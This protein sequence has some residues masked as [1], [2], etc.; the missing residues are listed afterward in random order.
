ME[1]KG[2]HSPA[3]FTLFH[4]IHLNGYKC[5]LTNV[6]LIGTSKLISDLLFYFLLFF[7]CLCVYMCVQIQSLQVEHSE[8]E[9]RIGDYEEELTRA[10]EELLQLQEE[11]RQLGDKVQS[12][13]DQ[14]CPL[15]DAVKE[16]HTQIA[17]VSE[18]F[19]CF[20]I[21][22]ALTVPEVFF[23]LMNIHIIPCFFLKKSHVLQ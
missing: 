8:Q 1:E 9:Q 21:L 12:A 5:I 13:R 6:P 23:L 15:E 22:S 11:T 19:I 4:L 20:C 14:L 7:T 3:E 2:R 17:Q 18:L 10:R 16:S